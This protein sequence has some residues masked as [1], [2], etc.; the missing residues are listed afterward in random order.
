MNHRFAGSALRRA[1]LQISQNLTSGEEFVGVASEEFCR[2]IRKLCMGADR[3]NIGITGRPRAVAQAGALPARGGEDVR[4]ERAR[5]FNGLPSFLSQA[6]AATLPF[7][8][9]PVQKLLR[10]LGV[11]TGFR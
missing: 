4:A 5:L 2:S 7:L 8:V 11:T 3:V 6:H 9:F 10:M 1:C